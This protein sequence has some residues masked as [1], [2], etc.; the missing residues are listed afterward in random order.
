M[1][2]RRWA[3]DC[4]SRSLIGGGPV[5][6]ESVGEE[7]CRESNRHS[8]SQGSSEVSMARFMT[9]GLF[10]GKEITRGKS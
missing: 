3:G 9:V 6:L 7:R 4:T 10:V 1:C 8:F 5:N 2:V